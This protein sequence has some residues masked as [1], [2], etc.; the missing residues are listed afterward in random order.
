MKKILI[1]LLAVFVAIPS[2]NAATGSH[3]GNSPVGEISISAS[4]AASYIIPTNSYLRDSHNNT[5]M[6]TPEVR[7]GFSF[8][9][10]TRYGRLYHGVTQGIGFSWNTILPHSSLGH[11]AGIFLFQTVPFYSSGAI[12]FEAGWDF[13]ISTPWQHFEYQQE[14]TN[15]AI[16]SKTNALLGVSLGT[17]YRLNSRMAIK[18]ALTATHYSNGNTHL[19]NAGVNTTGLRLGFIY[20]IGHE[21]ADDTP[22]T[23]LPDD[24]RKGF[25]YDLTV[26]GATRKRVVRDSSGDNIIAPGS[27]GVAGLNFAPMYTFGRYLRAGVS[28]DMQYDESANLGPNLVEGTYGDEVRFY[29]QSFT[30]RFSAGLSLRGELTLPIFSIGVGIGRNLIAKGDNRAF[31]QILLLKAYVFRGA[32]LQAGY[33]LH[34]FHEPSNLMLGVGYT[35]GH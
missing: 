2:G 28:L 16:G 14:P 6:V 35:F 34:D 18:A 31:Y 20:T 3:S 11:P 5:L 25:G 22:V 12:S 7:A 13:G 17:V 24:F 21:K 26:Y 19:P 30:E 32:F 10:S 23:P 9:R 29:R 1:P 8:S 15:T 33:R 27:F 4:A